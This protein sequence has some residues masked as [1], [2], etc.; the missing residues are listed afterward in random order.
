M[1]LQKILTHYM[2]LQARWPY[3]G[4]NCNNV[5]LR[6]YEN[7]IQAP[8]HQWNWLHVPP[9]C[10]WT[11]MASIG[12]KLMRHT[13]EKKNA[14][15]RRRLDVPNVLYLWNGRIVYH[16]IHS[17]KNQ[18]QHAFC[19][20]LTAEMSHKFQWL[21]H[22][23]LKFVH[24]KNNFP[25]RFTTEEKESYFLKGGGGINFLKLSLGCWCLGTCLMG[26]FLSPRIP[27]PVL[28]AQVLSARLY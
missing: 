24:C 15:I 26:G 28:V 11:R 14:T 5:P 17:M 4:C 22:K 16:T 6:E 9:V 7:T 8:G 25:S 2:Q 19:T 3:A 12:H 20:H 1:R 18:F 10:H 27:W 23:F 13:Q 21:V